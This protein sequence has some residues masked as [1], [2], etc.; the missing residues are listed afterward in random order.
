MASNLETYQNAIIENNTSS[1]Q[2]N[3]VNAAPEQPSVAEKAKTFFLG[4]GNS[5]AK[6]N[7]RLIEALRADNVL[8]AKDYS[9]F[10]GSLMASINLTPVSIDQIDCFIEPGKFF[11][12]V[13]TTH[14]PTRLTLQPI[15]ATFDD[16]GS[17]VVSGFSGSNDGTLELETKDASITGTED[18]K[19]LGWFFKITQFNTMRGK[20]AVQF[21]TPA[22]T[23]AFDMSDPKSEARLVVLSTSQDKTLSCTAP[24]GQTVSGGGSVVVSPVVQSSIRDL[25]A[26]LDIASRSDQTL[27]NTLLTMT[28]QNVNVYAFPIVVSREVVDSLADLFAADEYDRL[29]GH[30]LNLIQ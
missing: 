15:V 12:K 5:D 1:S 20:S 3:L 17:L 18:F 22:I 29:A 25:T 27:G 10:N 6:A 19:Q 11:N 14:A 7:A 28:A 24:K 23:A 8:D 16:T 13:A 4:K 9:V 21:K 30:F 2:Q 26:F